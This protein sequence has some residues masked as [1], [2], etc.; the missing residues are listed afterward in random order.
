MNA[1]RMTAAAT[2]ALALSAAPATHAQPAPSAADAAKVARVLKATPLIDGHD[3]LT[4][5]VRTK[6]GGDPAKPRLAEEAAAVG[7]KPALQTDIPRLRRGGVGGQFWS[8]YVPPGQLGPDSVKM[9]LEQIA[10]LRE[11]VALHPDTFE[12]AYTA[13]DVVRIHKAGRIASLVGMEGGHS[14]DNSMAVLRA[15]YQAGA[16]Y[17]TLAHS[18]NTAWSDSA[19]DKPAHDGLTPFGEAIVHEMNRL[20]MLVDLSHVSDATMRDALRVTQ[21]AVIFSHSSARALGGVSRNVPDDVLKLVAANGGVV[22][23][24]FVPGFLSPDGKAWTEGLFAELA[25]G[26]RRHPG[27]EAAA[28]ADML[29]WQKTHPSPAAT[30]AMAADHIDHIRRVAGVDNV[31]LGADYDGGA[32]DLPAGLEDVSKYPALLAELS[33]RGWSEA[34]LRKL[35]GE[36]VLRALRGAEA[37]A[38]RLSRETPSHATLTQPR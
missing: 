21:A 32:D 26:A 18:E 36:N 29:A 11:I 4:W 3:D 23:V 16:R 9:T 5:E 22:M 31:G 12:M 7:R 37:T 17:M 38:Q 27:D 30:L 1:R 35:A 13:A 24:A 19:T 25:A 14:I 20:G 6:F 28:A 10:L 8:V 33:R 34:D 2:L 15:F